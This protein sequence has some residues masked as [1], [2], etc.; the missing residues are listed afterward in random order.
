MGCTSSSE[1]AV[2]PSGPVS[3][4][5]K[6]FKAAPPRVGGREEEEEDNGAGVRMEESRR[7]GRESPQSVLH[8]GDTDSESEA[9]GRNVSAVPEPV[10]LPPPV[11]GSVVAR[12]WGPSLAGILADMPYESL[13]TLIKS[14]LDN[15]VQVRVTRITENGKHNIEIVFTDDEGSVRKTA[16]SW[17]AN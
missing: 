3:D 11:A 10:L 15:G 5:R 12:M 9:E 14:E 2:A 8:K 1:G 16:G 17:D 7:G 4:K 6:N 13:V